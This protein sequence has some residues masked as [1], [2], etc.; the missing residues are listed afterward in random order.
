MVVIQT[1]F[2]RAPA[3]A[4]TLTKKSDISY[5]IDLTIR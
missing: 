4:N 3:L 1:V 2:A 5:L